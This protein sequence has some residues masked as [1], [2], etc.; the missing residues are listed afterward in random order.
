MLVLSTYDFN[1][2]IAHA[3]WSVAGLL[4][5]EK[6]RT[7]LAYK[8]ARDIGLWLANYEV[9]GLIAEITTFLSLKGK[10]VMQSNITNI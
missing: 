3:L 2:A 5:P 7:E 1:S 8:L 6:T 9:F 4:I 10:T